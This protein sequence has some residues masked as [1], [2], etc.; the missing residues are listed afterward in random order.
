MALT[1][2]T[3][4]PTAANPFHFIHHGHAGGAGWLYVH[5]GE[6]VIEVCR[7]GY[8]VAEAIEPAGC[9]V[10]DVRRAARKA[11]TR[12]LAGRVELRRPVRCGEHV[13]H[14]GRNG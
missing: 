11:V 6:W 7:D 9:P 8:W 10:A 13:A 4:T 1:D 3:P 14:A 5:N 12:R 2:S